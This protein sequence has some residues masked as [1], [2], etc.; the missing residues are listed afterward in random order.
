MVGREVVILQVSHVLHQER[1]KADLM[2]N[3]AVYLSQARCFLRFATDDL[4]LRGPS[5][6]FV[7]IKNP[8]RCT[9]LG[10]V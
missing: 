4:V 6:L 2:C 3:P 5:F 8:M 9:G 1:Q 7:E 10:L